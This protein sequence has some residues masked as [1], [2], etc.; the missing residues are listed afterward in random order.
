MKNSQ[1]PICIIPARSGSKR[2]KNKNIINFMGKPIIAYSIL[3]AVKSKLFKRIIV[4]TDS[5][6]I[7]KISEKYGAEVP[8]LRSKKLS[9]D[10]T[11]TDQVVRDCIKNLRSEDVAYHFC[12]YPTTPM[13]KKKDLVVSFK[14][15]KKLKFDRLISVGKYSSSPLRA[16]KRKKNQITFVNKKYIFKRSQDL[17]SFYFDAGSFY[18]FRTKSIM[19]YKAIPKRST[20]H[21]LNNV[22]DINYKDDLK[23][24]KLFFKSDK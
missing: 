13:L 10:Y 1:K 20:F 3:L 14:K 17:P 22:V 4:S 5:R 2:I 11:G 18:I 9:D 19:N 23:I 16:F 12:I 6:K 15:I 21:L 8:F 7:K 24:L